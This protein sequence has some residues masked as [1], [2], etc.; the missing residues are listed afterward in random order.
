MS[1]ETK[2]TVYETEEDAASE[3]EDKDSKKTG[4]VKWI[5]SIVA[6]VCVIG[7]VVGCILYFTKDGKSAKKPNSTKVPAENATEQATE[8]ES[9]DTVKPETKQKTVLIPV[10]EGYRWGYINIDGEL[11]IET[12]YDYAYEFSEGLAVV[13]VGEKY[14]YINESGEYIATPQFDNATRFLDGL[15]RVELGDKFGYINKEGKY[16][17]VPQYEK[18]GAFSEGLAFVKVGDLYGYVNKK[19]EMVIEPQFCNAYKFSDGLACVKIGGGDVGVIDGK[20]GYINKQGEFVINPQFD[21]AG[22]FSEG[23]AY[24]TADKYRDYIYAEDIFL[25][26]NAK[27]GYIN[28]KGEM[29]IEPQF[30]NAEDFSDGLAI[31]WTS[32]SECRY[33]NTEGEMV[34]ELRCD[35]AEPFNGGIA[36][37]QLGYDSYAC[38]NKD[39]KIISDREFKYAYKFSDGIVKVS[40]EDDDGKIKCGLLGEDGNYIVEPQ[41]KTIED[42]SQGLAVV[43]DG[44]KYGYINTKGELVSGFNYC[45]A[46][47]FTKQGYA[48]VAEADKKYRVIDINGNQIG[49]LYD[50]A[51]GFR[52]CAVGDCL[53]VADNDEHYCFSHGCMMCGNRR[54]SSNAYYCAECIA[55]GIPE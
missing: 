17:I 10:A 25:Y 23:L 43:T 2:E 3:V 33:I 48:V 39:G 27:Y 4:K 13:K 40:I 37:V 35:D 52:L 5:V 44:E 47:S 38:I 30:K 45:H 11:A 49:G 20:F 14:G 53:K 32:F 36:V 29:V 15:A 31:V 9:D 12:K 34:I 22:N 28:T 8:K 46:G 26:E 1:E 19:G 42:L 21:V 24:V 16:V 54:A 50:G 18:L 55:N 6:L 41:Y 7:V 51:G